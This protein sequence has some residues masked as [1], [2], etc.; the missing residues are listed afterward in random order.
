VLPVSVKTRIAIE[1]ASKD[2]WYKYVGLEGAVVGLSGYGYSAP[3]QEAFKA[4]GLTVEAIVDTAVQ[5]MKKNAELACC[6]G[7]S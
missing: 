4:L 6:V 7:E 5:L 1:A 2:F 3:Y